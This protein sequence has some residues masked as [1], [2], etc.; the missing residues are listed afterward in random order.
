MFIKL[1]CYKNST[2]THNKSSNWVP[3]PWTILVVPFLP[4][5]QL[6]SSKSKF[7]TLVPKSSKMRNFHLLVKIVIWAQ[8]L[9]LLHKTSSGACLVFKIEPQKHIKW[10][11]MQNS[12]T[13]VTLKNALSIVARFANLRPLLDSWGWNKFGSG[14]IL[15]FWVLI[16]L[17][18]KTRHNLI[19]TFHNS[20][21]KMWFFANKIKPKHLIYHCEAYRMTHNLL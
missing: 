12:V 9:T 20:S 6:P 8:N 10:N 21:W 15:L 11:C 1:K 5:Q 4:S 16:N 3:T 17:A 13:R 2:K 14:L 19:L 7:S 18:S